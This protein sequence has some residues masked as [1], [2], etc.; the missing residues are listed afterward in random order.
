MQTQRDLVTAP[1][2]FQVKLPPGSGKKRR[3][4]RRTVLGSLVTGMMPPS[5][6]GKHAYFLTGG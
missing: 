5:F 1:K 4:V 6:L 3:L 2:P